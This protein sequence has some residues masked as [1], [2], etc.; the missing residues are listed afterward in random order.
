MKSYVY[1]RAG[2]SRLIAIAGTVALLLFLHSAAFAAAAGRPV[3]ANGTVKTADGQ[4]LRG[5]HAHIR[6]TN[7]IT[8]FFTDINNVI[9]LRDQAHMNVIRICLLTPDW[10]GLSTPDAQIATVDAIVANCET[11][12]IYAIINCHGPFPTDGVS[13]WDLKKFWSIYAP[14]Y[15]DKTFVIYELTNETFPGT[16]PDVL[17]SNGYTG[18]PT[19]ATY[20]AQTAK[21]VIRPVAPNNL[22]FHCEPVCVTM[23]WGPYLWNTYAPMAGITWNSGKDAWA[24][25]AYSGTG[26]QYI[27][28][29]QKYMAGIPTICTEFSF[30]EEGWTNGDLDGYH[31]PGE[32]CERNGMSWMVWQQ[33]QSGEAD[34]L[35]SVM[36]Y[37]LPD[38]VAKK[39][40]WWNIVPPSVPQNAA[41]HAV[42]PYNATVTWSASSD[43][44]SGICRYAIYRD[45]IRVGVAQPA[46][47][48]TFTDTALSSSTTY[49][50]QV[51][52]VTLGDVESVRSPA[53]SVTTP[54]DAIPPAAALVT[55]I[56][57]GTKVH[58][59]FSERV[60]R[61]SAT[62]PGNYSISGIA[63]S[64]AAL[65]ADLKT[66]T[67]SVAKM[68]KGVSY[69]L[70]MSNVKD[71]ATPP[72][73]VPVN[74][75]YAFRYVDGMTIFRFFPRAGQAA[76]MQNGVFEATNGS[77]TDGP[78]TL[79]YKIPNV[80]TEGFY[81][82]VTEA[83]WMAQ[84]DA[85]NFDRGYRY[86]RYRG[87]DGG[88]CNVA[89]IEF[90]SGSV[91]MTGAPFG[92]PG[93][94]QNSG[95]DFTKAFDGSTATFFDYS[96]PNGGYAGLDLGQ[97]QGVRSLSPE[98]AHQVEFGITLRN[99]RM[100]AVSGVDSRASMNV[101]LYD[102]RGNLVR[103]ATCGAQDALV[104][105]MRMDGRPRALAPGQYIVRVKNGPREMQR[106]LVV[107]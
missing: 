23:N 40:S 47:N 57:D 58:V 106:M 30:Q 94:N 43:A 42:D 82:V 97:R 29:T 34:Q 45:N 35:K 10:G 24:F 89:E 102:M 74:T 103:A 62:T 76:K 3:I 73:A 88:S 55:G 85:G 100:I 91:K 95:N 9:K 75:A 14:R 84:T 67:L 81:T 6:S 69:S 26:S 79:I 17:P 27:L 48:M 51:A 105:L 54:A 53:I 21:S 32:W 7:A 25:H 66:L 104:P 98:R 90:Y 22:I 60:D 4:L 20:I 36:N 41:V 52:A 8:T 72:N 11:A 101:A 107:P 28:A 37:L 59:I 12:G 56:G 39:W 70:V 16:T 2:V 65:A 68:S 33:W 80:P 71:L 15:K 19:V 5:C 50:Y 61:T 13:A 49:S 99:Q 44:G 86:F 31:Y 77:P 93:S 1:S 46:S 78:Y 96:Q 38:A 92:T 18:W 63:I 87:P 64:A 83:A